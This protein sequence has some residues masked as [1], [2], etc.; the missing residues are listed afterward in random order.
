MS[1]NTIRQAKVARHSGTLK[2]LSITMLMYAEGHRTGLLA[3][4]N[5]A[6]FHFLVE[7]TLRRY[8]PCCDSGSICMSGWMGLWPTQTCRGWSGQVNLLLFCLAAHLRHATSFCATHAS[9]SLSLHLSFFFPASITRQSCR[10]KGS[11]EGPYGE[12]IYNALPGAGVCF[13]ASNSRFTATV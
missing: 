8:T 5:P 9:R 12:S 2:P 4:T 1:R 13:A 6:R 7:P 10:R 3:H 11:P